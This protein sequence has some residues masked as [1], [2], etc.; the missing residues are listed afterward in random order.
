MPVPNQEELV[1]FSRDIWSEAGCFVIN[2]RVQM[3][4]KCA[5][6]YRGLENAREQFMTMA[7]DIKDVEVATETDEIQ[8]KA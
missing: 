7:R 2:D 3:A 8:R 5:D 6:K 1:V 4:G